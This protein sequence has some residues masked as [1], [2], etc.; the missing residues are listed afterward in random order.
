MKQIFLVLTFILV[1]KIN[2]QVSFSCNYTQVCYWNSTSKEYTNCSGSESN[3]LFAFNKEFTMFTHTTEEMKSTYYITSS[4]YD[5][6][7]E[8]WFYYTTSDVGNKYL[9]IVD[10]KNKQIRTLPLKEGAD[11]IIAYTIKASF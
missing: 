3:C 2:A 7:K 6:S 8:I 4:E 11:Y 1:A 5:Q 9:F 10:P